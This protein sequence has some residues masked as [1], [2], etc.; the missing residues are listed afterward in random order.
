MGSCPSHAQTTL[1]TYR[2]FSTRM[3]YFHYIIML[4]IHHS[5]REPSIYRQLQIH[6]RRSST[7]TNTQTVPFAF[8]VSY[9]F[10][11]SLSLC[12]CLS[13][14]LSGCVC[15]S[16]TGGCTCGVWS[17]APREAHCCEYCDELG[18]DFCCGLL[19]RVNTMRVSCQ[20]HVWPHSE[21]KHRHT[22]KAPV[23]MHAHT[24]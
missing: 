21:N 4:E 22:E 24:R 16:M 10:A 2:G 7:R 12:P 13:A 19:F 14:C 6:R 3:V 17:A 15:R 18:E 23:H 1:V 8:I 9:S 20:R 11:G 5:G